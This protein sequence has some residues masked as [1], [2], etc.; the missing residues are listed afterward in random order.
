M[1]TVVEMVFG[2]GR[3]MCA[4]NTVAFTEL[5]KIFVEVSYYPWVVDRWSAY[6]SHND[7]SWNSS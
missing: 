7:V 1:T 6:D 5:N 4:G 2:Y 3:W